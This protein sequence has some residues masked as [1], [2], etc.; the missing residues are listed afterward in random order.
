MNVK[1]RAMLV[2]LSISVWNARSYDR[3]ISEKIAKEHNTVTDVGRYN[4]RLLNKAKSYES[5]IQHASDTRKWHYAN[6]LPWSDTGAR[7]LTAQN[8]LHYSEEYRHRKERLDDLRSIFVSEYP[9]LKEDSKTLLNGLYVESDYPMDH[10]IGE[11]FS[12]KMSIYPLPS[13]EDFRVDLGDAEVAIIRQRIEEQT[14]AAQLVAMRDLWS[15][16]HEGV[17]KLV[18]R[19]GDP[20]A[21][22]RDT[23]ITN[24]RDLCSLL[25]RLNLT[26]DP[27]LENTRLAVEEKL[28]SCDPQLL[29][30]DAAVRARVAAEAAKIQQTMAAY[31]GG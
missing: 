31:M 13:G 22:F 8:F 26:N 30:H 6:T 15:R 1:E 28:A 18:Q 20:D 7:I 3:N 19:L 24:L 9:G 4:K 27:E 2:A 29:R 11:R 21:I 14:Q 23:L 17:S 10:E 5:I 25:P 16:L 12:M